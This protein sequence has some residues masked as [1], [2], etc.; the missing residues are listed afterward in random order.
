LFGFI[1]TVQ[2]V[3]KYGWLNFGFVELNKD[4]NWKEFIIFC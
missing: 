2:T 1:V 3:V 4:V